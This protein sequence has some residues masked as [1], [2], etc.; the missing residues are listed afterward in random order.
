MNSPLTAAAVNYIEPELEYRTRFLVQEARK[1]CHQSHAESRILQPSHLLA[2]RSILRAGHGAQSS[3]WTQHPGSSA[4]KLVTSSILLPL[5]FSDADSNSHHVSLESSSFQSSSR[6]A[7]ALLTAITAAVG[8]DGDDNDRGGSVAGVALLLAQLGAREAEKLEFLMP[9]IVSVLRL[10]AEDA[11]VENVAA[12][13]ALNASAYVNPPSKNNHKVIAAALHS[14]FKRLRRVVSLFSA[15]SANDCLTID[16]SVGEILAALCSIL[17]N[18]PKRIGGSFPHDLNQQQ[19]QQQQ[20]QLSQIK[21][22]SSLFSEVISQ[23]KVLQDDEIHLRSYAAQVLG[24]LLT[25][26]APRWPALVPQTTGALLDA[27]SSSLEM[28]AVTASDS[29]G[30]SSSATTITEPRILKVI[31]YE[32]LYG[33]AS[34]LS[35]IPQ[36]SDSS[37]SAVALKLTTT[38]SN[39]MKTHLAILEDLKSN[40]PDSMSLA[41]ISR[42]WCVSSLRT[43]EKSVISLSGADVTNDLLMM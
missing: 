25:R 18:N 19:Q 39:A 20:Q 12:T 6:E 1:V 9:R 17:L 42:S 37:T 7:A 38:I 5:P 16:N 14:S 31:S 28:A 27:M 33:S 30:S 15:L 2:A 35:C 4:A 22:N 21:S 24:A 13:A 32:C 34:G 41:S 26:I 40:I 3:E 10:S 43:L 8:A 11:L 23:L 29:A 36:N